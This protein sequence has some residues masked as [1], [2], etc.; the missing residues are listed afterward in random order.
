LED[1]IA[2]LIS[3]WRCDKSEPCKERSYIILLFLDEKKQK[4][5]DRTEFTKN[6]IFTLKHFYSTAAQKCFLTR[7][8]SIFLT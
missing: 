6:L 7:K 8:Q 3:V 4:S 5:S 2:V 1:E